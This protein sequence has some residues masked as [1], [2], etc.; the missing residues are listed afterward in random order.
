MKFP[1]S[2]FLLF[3]LLGLAI[4][5]T[6][7]AETRLAPCPSSPNCISSQAQDYHYIAPLAITGDPEAAFGKLREILERRPD[8]TIIEADEKIVRV[9]FRTT[10][11]FVDDGIFALDAE[12]RVINIRSAS[13]TGYWDFGKNRRRME[14]IRKE[15]HARQR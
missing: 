2:T 3:H 4:A 10:L 15:F 1:L 11:G 7:M 6:A 13:R 9:E 8:T 12:N 14:E 5:M